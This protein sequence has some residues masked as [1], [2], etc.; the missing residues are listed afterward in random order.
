MQSYHDHATATPQ[1]PPSA[2]ELKVGD[3]E[4]QPAA[5]VEVECLRLGLSDRDRHGD[6]RTGSRCTM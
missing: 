4:Q 2:A 1:S 6:R 3:A 5:R